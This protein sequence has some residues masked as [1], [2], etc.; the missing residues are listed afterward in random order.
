[1]LQDYTY[2]KRSHMITTFIEFSLV[3]I[4][5]QLILYMFSNPVVDET[6]QFRLIAHSNTVEDQFEKRLIADQ[7]APMIQDVYQSSTTYEQID[8]RFQVSTADFLQTAQRIVPNRKI[9]FDKQAARIPA[10]R[11]GIFIQPEGVYEAYVMK[12]GQARGDNWWCALF[13]DVCFPKEEV[14]EAEE[15]DGVT[16]FL[17]EWIKSLF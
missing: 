12:I 10:K 3:L 8:E 16:F 5:F 14:Q 11:N 17:W 9:T 7:L 13:S 2:T 15:S 1:M 4:I 6:V